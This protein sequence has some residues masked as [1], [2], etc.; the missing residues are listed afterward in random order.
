VTEHYFSAQPAGE[1]A[2]HPVTLTLDGREYQLS[3]AR[4]VFSADHVDAGTMVLLENAPPPPAQGDLLDLGCGYG[5]IACAMALRSPRARVF[6]V[7]VNERALSLTRGNADALGLTNVSA[8]TPDET[9]EHLTF[10]RIYSNPPIRVGKAVLRAT[11]SRWLARLADGGRGYLV[12]HRNLGSDSLHAWL[13]EQGYDT[14]R[15]VSVRGFRVLEVRGQD[16]A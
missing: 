5:P 13:Q 3:A 7:D 14:T 2:P 11:L 12:V 10:D 1:F 16:T 15:L 4:G 9:P 6:G 8:G